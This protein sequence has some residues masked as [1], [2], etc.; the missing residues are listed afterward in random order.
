[1]TSNRNVP[2]SLASETDLGRFFVQSFQFHHF[3]AA[4]IVASCACVQLPVSLH[5]RNSLGIGEIPSQL[6]QKLGHYAL[7]TVNSYDMFGAKSTLP[8]HW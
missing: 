4:W 6:V 7:T 5:V 2:A 3:T 8:Q 1:V